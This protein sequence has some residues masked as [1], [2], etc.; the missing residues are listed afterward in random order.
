M[1][2]TVSYMWARGLRERKKQVREGISTEQKLEWTLV[3]EQETPRQRKDRCHKGENH[4]KRC[5]MRK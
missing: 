4:G 2:M 1:T 3:E 5:F